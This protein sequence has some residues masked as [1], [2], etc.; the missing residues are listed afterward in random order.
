MIYYSEGY[1]PMLSHHS[2]WRTSLALALV[3]TLAGSGLALGDDRLTDDRGA[4]GLWRTLLELRTTA[5]A[6]HITAHP[7]DEDGP[8][9]TLLARG[10]G[11]HTMLLSLNRGEGGANLIAPFFF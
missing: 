5:S 9:L 11:V 6:L 4:A 8:S 7:D 3:L 1:S 2:I 10:Q